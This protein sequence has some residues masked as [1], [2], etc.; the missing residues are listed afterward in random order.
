MRKNLIYNYIEKISVEMLRHLIT[1]E[2]HI[3]ECFTHLVL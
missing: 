3:Y 1:T 2:G